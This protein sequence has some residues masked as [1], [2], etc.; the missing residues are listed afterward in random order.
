MH[1]YAHFAQ[2]TEFFRKSELH[3]FMNKTETQLFKLIL[4][5]YRHMF[6]AYVDIQLIEWSYVK[7][8]SYCSIF[9]TLA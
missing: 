5:I 2:H 8:C 1:I 6:E 9:L 7:V 4:L 3:V